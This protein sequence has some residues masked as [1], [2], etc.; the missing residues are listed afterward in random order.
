MV[1]EFAPHTQINRIE[2]VGSS[3]SQTPLPIQLCSYVVCTLKLG[4]GGEAP[5]KSAN[6]MSQAESA[7]VPRSYPLT[8]TADECVGRWVSPHF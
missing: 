4:G 6:R 7:V 5:D 3:I 1:S 8:N 2:M